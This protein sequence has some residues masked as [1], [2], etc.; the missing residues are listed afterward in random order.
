[1]ITPGDS[2]LEAECESEDMAERFDVVLATMLAV[3][4]PALKTLSPK[5]PSSAATLS[6]DGMGFSGDAD[7]GTCSWQPHS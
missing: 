4:S 3:R 7:A 1:M 5:M 6:A 2:G